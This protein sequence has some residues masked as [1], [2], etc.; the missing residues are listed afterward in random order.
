[1]KAIKAFLIFLI[2][3]QGCKKEDIPSVKTG[4]VA[5]VTRSSANCSGEILSQGNSEV[6]GR[7][8]CWST[9][10]NPMISDN[11]KAADS[12]GNSFTVD[13][14]GLEPGTEYFVRA[15]ATNTYGTGYGNI[16]SFRTEPAAI[17]EVIASRVSGINVI[18]I[19]VRGSINSDGA[20][21]ITDRGF[22]W[23]TSVNPDLSDNVISIGAGE[24]P[25]SALIEK[26][27]SNTCYYVRAYA[28]NGIGTGYS[29]NIV[30]V[31]PFPVFP[32]YPA[33]SIFG[34]WEWIYSFGG[35]DGGFHFP[36]GN[37]MIDEYSKDSTFIE[38]INSNEYRSCRFSIS[39]NALKYTDKKYFYRINIRGENLNIYIID[40]LSFVPIDEIGSHYFKRVK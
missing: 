26:L 4:D 6:I 31:T 17:P 14:T 18:P 38:R 22:C 19:S 33:D 13:L 5:Y 39:G 25:F 35:I 8:I 1:M 23:D 12:D 27:D 2:L 16:N 20:S 36:G 24:D 11:I 3:I 29:E 10:D 7:G 37:I 9:T 28:T 21:S 40:T 34:R 30:T 32:V 15:Y